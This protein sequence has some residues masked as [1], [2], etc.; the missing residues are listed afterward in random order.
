MASVSH[1]PLV[2]IIKFDFFFFLP[3]L[4]INTQIPFL[5]L[6]HATKYR[7]SDCTRKHKDSHFVLFL[8]WMLPVLPSGRHYTK[9]DHM[10]LSPV[11]IDVWNRPR[12]E[13]PWGGSAQIRLTKFTKTVLCSS[14]MVT[15]SLPHTSN[16]PKPPHSPFL[17]ATGFQRVS[18]L[19]RGNQTS[20]FFTGLKMAGPLGV[21]GCFFQELRTSANILNPHGRKG[22]LAV[23]QRGK[24]LVCQSSSC[25]EYHRYCPFSIFF[26]SADGD[27]SKKSSVS[28]MT[29]WPA[30]GLVVLWYH[31]S[32]VLMLTSKFQRIEI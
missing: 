1:C 17:R 19:A 12:C 7:P 31:F 24:Y 16:S 8:E 2:N 9:Q 32:L 27:K 18:R 29:E 22:D 4:F 10:K 26:T 11:W 21:R 15:H 23:F 3:R 20:V 6:L 14:C 30:G 25:F 5:I 28:W 13:G